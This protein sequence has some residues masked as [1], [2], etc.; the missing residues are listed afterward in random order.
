MIFGVRLNEDLSVPDDVQ[1]QLCIYAEEDW[2][3]VKSN[4]ARSCEGMTVINH[5]GKYYMTY[6]CNHYTDPNYGIGYATADSPLGMWIK[7]D[8][9]PILTKNLK[10]GISGP[11]HNDLVKSPD[12]SEWFIV[13]HSHADI[14]NPSGKRILNIDRLVFDENGNMKVIGPSRTPQPYPSGAKPEKNDT[15]N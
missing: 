2:E 9:N 5:K 15:Q 10:T 6:S 12:G 13:Y 8:M 1:H 4:H 3:G 11:G 14:N 7:S